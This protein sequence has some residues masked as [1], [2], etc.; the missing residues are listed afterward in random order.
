M[1]TLYILNNPKLFD[2]CRS[3]MSENDAMLLIENAVIVSRQL[4]AIEHGFVLEEDLIARGLAQDTD[5]TKVSYKGFVEL[6][7][8]Y[9]KSVSWL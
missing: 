5:W 2:Q 3:A 6:T 7:L 9:D 4:P 8:E 1:K